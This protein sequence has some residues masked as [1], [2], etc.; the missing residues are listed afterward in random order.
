MLCLVCDYTVHCTVCITRYIVYGVCYCIYT[1][2]CILVSLCTAYSVTTVY[3]NLRIMN[4]IHY[5]MN[6]LY[7]IYGLY[8]IY[9][10][11]WPCTLHSV[12]CTLYTVHCTAYSKCHKRICYI[13]R[14]TQFALNNVYRIC[15]Y[16][17]CCVL[18]TTR[19]SV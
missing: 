19:R 16:V 14:R 18:Y 7:L 5:I 15:I 13:R 11:Q 17:W 6:V 2:Y 10:K 9:W 12:H 1:I 4:N 8:T 3:T